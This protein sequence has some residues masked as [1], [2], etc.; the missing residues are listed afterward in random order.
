MS[1]VSKGSSRDI[2]FLWATRGKDWGF[3]FLRTAGQP[4]PLEIYETA[5]RGE[6]R[7]PQTLQIAPG[8]IAIRV[9]DPEGRRDAAGR[10]IPHEFVLFRPLS[11]EISSA[12]DALNL[13][14]PLVK[15]D[16][17]LNWDKPWPMPTDP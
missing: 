6:M 11:A 10:V 12:Q 13:V 2:A 5:F 14:W 17:A 16:F 7:A 8:T 15:D 9:P 3:R 1:A 4:N